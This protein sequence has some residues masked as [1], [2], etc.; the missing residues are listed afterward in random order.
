MRR[1]IQPR[2]EAE[3]KMSTFGHADIRGLVTALLVSV[4]H[5]PRSRLEGLLQPR[6]DLEGCAITGAASLPMA[7]CTVSMFAVLNGVD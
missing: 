1:G 5:L 6:N 4:G 3:P 7:E 2:E